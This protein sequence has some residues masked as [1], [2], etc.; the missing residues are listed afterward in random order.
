MRAR[1]RDALAGALSAA[2]QARADALID[3]LLDLP[4]AER[5][6]DLRRLASDD[7]AVEAEVESLLNAASSCGN[8]LSR[9]AQPSM[10]PSEAPAFETGLRIGPWRIV[11][12]IGHGGMGEVYEAERVDGGFTQRAAVKL[13]RRE[14]SEQL[15]RFHA[16]RQIL[17]RLD[18]PGIASLHDGGVAPDGRPWMAMEFVEGRTLTTFCAETHATLDQR[19][20]LFTQVCDAVAYAHHHFVVHRDLKPANILVNAEGKVKLLDFG[21]AKLLDDA[22]GDARTRTLAAPLTPLY[23]APEQLTGGAITTATDVY[24]LGV[25]LFELLTGGP[26]WAETGT[27]PVAQVLRAVHAYAAPLASAA[28][29]ARGDAPV[30]PRLLRGDL[31]AIVAKALRA[32]P[33]HRYA[34]VDALRRDI[35]HT[36]HGESVSAR[37]GAR[38]Y[39]LGH[40]LRRYRWAAATAGAVFVALAIGLGVAAWQA[41]R[42]AIE[43][44]IA[45]RDAA[46]EEALRY[47]LTGLFRN[48]IADHASEAPTAKSMLDKSAQRVL[49][50]YRDQPL[51]AGQVVLAL[52]DLYDAL[53]DVQ[54]SAAL[55][56]GFLAESGSNADPF[57]VADA[58]QKL[59]GIELMRGHVERSGKLLDEAD[60]YWLHD[61]QPHAEERLEGMG[62]RARWQR[63]R[64]DLEGAIATDRSAIAQRIALSGQDHRET[65]T[66][67]NSLAITLTAANRLDEALAAYEKT[68]AIYDKLGL[69]DG[70]DAQI[71]RGNTGTLALR[72]GRLGEAESLL[73]GA[74]EQ[75]RVLAGD[76]AAVAASM[77]YYGKVLT[78]TNRPAQSIATLASAVEI[79][80]RYAG[81]TSPLTIQNRLFLGEAQLAAGDHAA[82]RTTLET[83]LRDAL[84]HYGDKHALALRT[85]LALAQLDNADG[86]RD[87]AKARLQT[88]VAAL[89]TIGAPGQTTLA[90]ALVALGEVE[91]GAGDP[92]PAITALQEALRLRSAG[93]SDT[94][95]ELAQTR[96]RLGEALAAGGSMAEARPLL[97]QAEATLQAQFGADH[98]ETLRARR[99]LGQMTD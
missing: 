95:W 23:A 12:D 93:G 72:T 15:E 22:G 5:L 26:P 4:G 42:A 78:I 35:E 80:T 81:A 17:A 85:E 71:I 28:A 79:G 1:K 98:P 51:L 13:L 3:A 59:A 31:D 16:E 58:R 88:V 76:S 41:H 40:V 7:P 73:K 43:R 68:S 83:D 77:G 70:L 65:A 61:P 8:F 94:S 75:E 64:G 33:A 63:A 36:R 27:T 97:T 2:Q 11:R 39:A 92:A 84:A 32:E 38:L 90:Q 29:A 24:A 66:L 45:L 50:E 60:V 53:E 49:R 82:A 56:E 34:T 54:G 9:P 6:A 14:A 62:V 21:V 47:H 86:R 57:A 91:L 44:D 55:L 52:A 69:G 87:E 37:E 18:H 96:E 30:A 48:A 19:L 25:L 99:A 67:Y 46:R 74:L 89:R 10:Q 20:Q